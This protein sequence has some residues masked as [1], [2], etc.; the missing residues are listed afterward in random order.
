MSKIAWRIL[1]RGTASVFFV[2]GLAVPAIADE[3][4]GEAIAVTSETQNTDAM[5]IDAIDLAGPI[6]ADVVLV[7]AGE[8]AG[9]DGA[10]NAVQVAQGITSYERRRRQEDQPAR[11]ETVTSRPRPQYDPLG[12]R[13]GSFVLFPSMTVQEQYETNIYATSNNE[14]D[15]FITRVMPG[16]TLRSDWNNHQLVLQT[17]G[18]IGFYADHT[19][20]DFQDYFVGGNGRIDVRRSTQLNLGA[21][22]RHTHESRESP[23]DPGPNTA[24]EPTQ[25]NIY[26]ATTSLRHD[27]GR[28]NATVGGS[29]DRLSF[30][31]PDAA[32]GGGTINEHDRDR[33]VYVGT[34]RVGYQIQPQYEAFVQGSYNKR[35]Y[36]G[37]EAGT[38]IDR[39][40]Q[41]YG[42]SVGM[43]VD[44]GG[45]V[46]GD[47][48][49]GYR[50]Q[51][52]EDSSLDSFGGF[53]GGADLTWNVTGLTTVT[54]LFTGDIRETTQ[55]GAS[56]RLV[57]TGEIGVDHELMRN[58]ILGGNI[59]LTR[60][61]YEGISRT[62]W[63]YGAGADATYLINRYLRAG[64]G[65]EFAK[66][67]SDI[68]NDDYTN[69]TFL[70]RVGLQY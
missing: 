6:A 25:L 59:N 36:D 30:E 5:D 3:A 10:A 35:V 18:D 45:I 70:V 53:G 37:T 51:D 28:I 32:V 55:T 9:A 16:V 12:V 23:D 7:N 42:A 2:A 52:Y 29:F 65:Y 19:K 62:D 64:L 8:P 34:V 41:G 46:F 44:F 4:G 13:V 43:E 49:A 24:D 15:D 69:H 39:D 68:S 50:Y 20:E 40:S 11:G 58:V 22:Y 67:D 33:D 66:R 61:D 48:F 1:V 38:G 21:R 47:F 60:D 27:F 31:D 17:G 56:G 57:T 14:K 63:I 26:S 54:A